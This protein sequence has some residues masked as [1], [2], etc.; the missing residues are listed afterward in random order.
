[1]RQRRS[2]PRGV[3]LGVLLAL[4]GGLGVLL[5]GPAAAHAVLKSTSPAAGYSTAGPVRQVTLTFSE[6]VTATAAAVSVSGPTVLTRAVA[7]PADGGRTLQVSTP[8]LRGG[9]YTVRW[10]VTADDGDVVTGTYQFA[11]GAGADSSRLRSH[12]RLDAV[13]GSM[14]GTAVLR[15]LV[16]AALA[17][18]LGGAAGMLLVHQLRAMAATERAAPLPS[19]V[20]LPVRVGCALGAVAAALLAAHAQNG[21]SLAEGLA[22]LRPWHLRGAAAAPLTEAMLFAL[23]AALW[24]RRPIRVAAVLP[25]LGVAVAEGIRGHLREQDGVAGAALVGVHIAVAAAWTGALFVIA[26]TAARWRA[27]GLVNAAWLLVH[28]YSRAAL[29]AYLL[30]T[31]TGTVAALLLFPTWQPLISTRYG[32]ALLVKLGVVAAVTALALAGRFRLRRTESTP[33]AHR[34]SLTEPA[35]LTVALLAAAVLVSL[36]P[37]RL[38]AAAAAPVPPPAP[39]GPLVRLGALAGQLTVG[40]TVAAGQVRVQVSSPASDDE[41]R[42]EKFTVTATVDTSL[43]GSVASGTSNPG[44][45]PGA[46]AGKDRLRLQECGAGCFAA[47]VAVAAPGLSLDLTVD[48]PNW[49]G[50]SVH[51]GFPWPPVSAEQDLR[52]VLAVLARAPRLTW[53]ESVTSDTSRPAPIAVTL[54]DSGRQFLDTE[55]YGD[56][57][58]LAPVLLA[59][60]AGTHRFAFG[61]GDSIFIEMTTDPAGRLLGEQLI[62]PNHL[63]ERT[64][65]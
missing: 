58:G 53:L 7:R 37:P 25:L 22:S 12:T 38:L 18:G 57:S 31:G 23:A 27:A 4:W 11:V 55:V 21:A 20:T 48:S 36:V 47:P 56:G 51:F 35:A 59:S 19:G 52:Q 43:V 40:V 6:P 61:V 62:T 39:T 29:A 65:A 30:V 3:A 33:V 63:I 16:F 26:L 1:M 60:A 44:Q 14:L 9:V 41:G 49:R 34:L 42:R 50:G 46:R 64:F 10:Q 45:G 28:Q 54:H 17:V 13:T 8:D 24:S 32:V 2:G 5:A 15:W